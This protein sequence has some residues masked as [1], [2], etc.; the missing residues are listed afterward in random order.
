MSANDVFGLFGLA[1][2]AVP[3]VLLLL[4]KYR[5]IAIQRSS[6]LALLSCLL[7]YAALVAGSVY[8]K[9]QYDIEQASYDR[10]KNG[11]VEKSEVTAE[12]WAR[13]ELMT[14][15]TGLQLAPFTSAPFAIIYT[16]LWFMIAWAVARISRIWRM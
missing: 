3:P 1:A 11:F 14:R 5:V 16:G 10:N 9:H 7:I 15:D 4:R 6:I 8:L 2:I 13:V 12:E